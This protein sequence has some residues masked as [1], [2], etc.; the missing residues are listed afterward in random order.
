MAVAHILRGLR[1]VGTC[2]MISINALPSCRLSLEPFSFEI[3]GI[4]KCTEVKLWIHQLTSR[5]SVSE[6]SVLQ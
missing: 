1:V 4:G 5:G 2:R 3:S 6:I